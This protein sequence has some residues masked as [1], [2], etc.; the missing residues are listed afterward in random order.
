MA[1]SGMDQNRIIDFLKVAIGYACITT[2]TFQGVLANPFTGTSGGTNGGHIRLILNSSPS[3]S[4]TNGT[5]IAGGSYVAGTGITYNT[6]SSGSFTTPTYSS[7]Q[8]STSN[9]GSLQQTGMPATTTGGVEIWDSAGSPLRWW[10][11]QLTA[12]VT[13]N[14]NDTLLFNASAIVAA[15]VSL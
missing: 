12:P 1:N 5:E 14:A 2:G 10:W 8:A 3:S 9:S 11:G 4:N 15:V 13:T 7:P 6:G